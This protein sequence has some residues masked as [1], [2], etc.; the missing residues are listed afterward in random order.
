MIALR[1]QV[2]D[3]LIDNGFPTAHI[4]LGRVVRDEWLRA[5]DESGWSVE[6]IGDHILDLVF[7]E[8]GDSRG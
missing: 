6:E 1:K 8:I 7:P 3:W 4:Y 5:Y 2:E